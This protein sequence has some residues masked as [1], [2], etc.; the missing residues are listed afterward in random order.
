[1]GPKKITRSVCIFGAPCE[2]TDSGQL[3]TNKD[4]LAAMQME[5]NKSPAISS[6]IRSQSVGTFYFQ[7]VEGG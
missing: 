7:K 5:I 2:L 3:Y 1:M 4:I 6:I